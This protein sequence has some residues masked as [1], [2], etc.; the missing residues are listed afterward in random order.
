M[1]ILQEVISADV[2]TNGR[3]ITVK[4]VEFVFSIY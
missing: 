2:Q 3:E 4:Q 1:R